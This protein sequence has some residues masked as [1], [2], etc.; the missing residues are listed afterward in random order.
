MGLGFSDRYSLLHFA[1]GIIAYF[2][3]V[4]FVLWFTIHMIYEILENTNYGIK[5]INR[6]PYWPG[7]KE[8]PDSLLNSCGDQFYG[9]VGWLLGYIVSNLD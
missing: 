1:V 6:F 2:W 5:L 7:G 8:A 4:S 3:N 9:M